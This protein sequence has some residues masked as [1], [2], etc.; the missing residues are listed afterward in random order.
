MRIVLYLV[1][2][3]YSLL[4]LALAATYDD[5]FNNSVQELLKEKI[6]DNRIIIE[7]NYNSKDKLSNIIA[8]QDTISSLYLEQFDPSYNNFKVRII[9]HNKQ[10]ESISGK[11]V[12]LIKIPVAARYIKYGD[13]ITSIDLS[14]KKIKL[15]SFRGNYITNE[16]DII[17]MRA[18]KY[19]TMGSSF[20]TRDLVQPPVFSKGKQVE[21]TYYSKDGNLEIRVSGI[22]LGDGFIGKPVDVLNNNSGIEVRGIVVNENTVNVG[23]NNL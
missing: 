17:G 18:K 12:L 3:I 4:Q 7:I 5:L 6:T 11:Y 16:Q 20:Q 21:L 19:I 10:E 2:I 1:T 8:K 14:S 13:I 15:N 22:A 23:G 9:Y